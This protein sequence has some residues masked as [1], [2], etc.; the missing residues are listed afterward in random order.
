MLYLNRYIMLMNRLTIK[1]CVLLITSVA[2]LSIY[3]ADNINSRSINYCLS[4][5]DE[6]IIRISPSSAFLVLSNVVVNK[7]EAYLDVNV[8]LSSIRLLIKDLF[9]RKTYDSY[10]HIKT[11]NVD[12]ICLLYT[13]PSPRDA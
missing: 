1:I 11:N 12:Y 10:N 9:N 3:K 7:K 4:H 8:K 6:S 13:S 5:L 2:V